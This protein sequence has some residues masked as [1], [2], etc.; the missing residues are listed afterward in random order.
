MKFQVRS[1]CF[2]TNS[3][4]MHSLVM[5]RKNANQRMTKTEIRH[6]FYLDEPWHMERYMQNNREIVNIDN[7]YECEYGRSPF[8]VLCS[9]KEKLY[10]AIASFYGNNYDLASYINSM[11]KFETTLKPVL[12]E[13]IG[14]N[15]I[16][17]AF[18][19]DS[20]IVYTDT[21]ASGNSLE[22][23]EEVPYEKLVYIKNHK[24]VNKNEVIDGMYKN[25]DVD[26]RPIEKISC[27]VPCL[28]SVDH[29]SCGVLNGFLS[30][31]NI[32]IK[33]YL[34]RKDIMVIIDGDEYC[35]LDT[36]IDCGLVDKNNII[37]RDTFL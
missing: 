24:S 19:Y 4:S 23:F 30:K 21:N 2:E 17:L 28:G 37:N 6:E 3:S 27:K 11:K 10:Y 26:G 25:V 12:I 34:I 14:C 29:Q 31:H 33:D 35:V 18:E 1:S 36:M 16:T 32:S 22:D 8:Q 5:T 15:D 7:R 13:L 9:F 20:F